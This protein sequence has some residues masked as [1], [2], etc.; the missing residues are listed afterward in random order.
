[1]VLSLVLPTQLP[2]ATEESS[3]RSL[4][5]L[6]TGRIR[7]LTAVECREERGRK[8]G[9][10]GQSPEAQADSRRREKWHFS[11]QTANY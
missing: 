7:H 3:G 8:K 5:A 4:Y 11:E 9:E 6:R 10:M 2:P 1:M